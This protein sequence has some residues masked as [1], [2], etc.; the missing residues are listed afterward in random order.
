M[1]NHLAIKT[2]KNTKTSH[3]SKKNSNKNLPNSSKIIEKT[4]HV[5]NQTQRNSNVHPKNSHNTQTNFSNKTPNISSSKDEQ[6]NDEIDFISFFRK[7]HKYNYSENEL[8]HKLYDIHNI[9]LP[10]IENNT[11]NLPGF[12]FLNNS[13]FTT[14]TG[15]LNNTNQ[16]KK[17]SIPESTLKRN[18]NAPSHFKR[19]S[20]NT[21][22]NS[23]CKSINQDTLENETSTNF[24]KSKS[25]IHSQTLYSIQGSLT[26]NS[27][28]IVSLLKY[29]ASYYQKLGFTF[30]SKAVLWLLHEMQAPL[31]S[32]KDT[33]NHYFKKYLHNKGKNKEEQNVIMNYLVQFS[34]NKDEDF[35][36][37]SKSAR[38]SSLYEMDSKASRV[39]C[40]LSSDSIKVDHQKHRLSRSLKRSKRASST[41]E[42]DYF[43]PNLKDS[44]YMSE[45][46][47]N[48]TGGLDFDDEHDLEV[49]QADLSNSNSHSLGLSDKLMAINPAI[50]MYEIISYNENHLTHIET[51]KFNIF[52]LEKE[53]GQ[54]NI[55]PAIATYIFQK[56]NYYTS[57]D[58]DKFDNFLIEIVNGYN[59]RNPYHHVS[60]FYILLFIYIMLILLYLNIFYLSG[61][62]CCRCHSNMSYLHQKLQLCKYL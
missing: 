28:L 33:N 16:K 35:N 61:L 17:N 54:K 30:L 21:N 42:I 13:N 48:R 60:A 47:N 12:G 25:R 27:F 5:I 45:V 4:Q 43:K 19:D 7:E 18:S 50:P 41:N 8:Y 52:L 15:N 55:L 23:P 53:V 56:H 38:E 29:T 58:F 3:S 40:K 44:S 36:N 59:R 62:T 57:I 9:Q 24:D 1:S 10:E 2:S 11:V 31:A 14:L 37:A 51:A 6:N 34:N 22:T 39:N 32:Y 20:V 46:F 49:I 26:F